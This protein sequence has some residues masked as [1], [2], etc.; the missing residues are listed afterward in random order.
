MARHIHS[1]LEDFQIIHDK[2]PP[3]KPR[4]NLWWCDI[5]IEPNRLY[6]WDGAKWIP[7]GSIAIGGGNGVDEEIII[8]L[9]DKINNLQSQ[10]TL[11]AKE[12]ATKVSKQDF[13]KD[14][15]GVLQRVT[16]A[17]SSIS[18]TADQIQSKVSKE[19]YERE[20]G[21]VLQRITTMESS[22]T[23]TAESIKS[24][25][26]KDN[27]ISMINQSAEKIQISADKISF[28]GTAI[29]DN[30][31]GEVKKKMYDIEQAANQ[32]KQLVDLWKVS[33]TTTINGGLI[34]A[35]TITAK[36]LLIGNF[37]NLFSNGTLEFG[38]KGFELSNNARILTENPYNGKFSLRLTLTGSFND[39]VD[40]RPIKVSPGDKFKYSV[41]ARTNAGTITDRI[42]LAKFIDANG[43]VE[44]FHVDSQR[45]TNS[46]NSYNGT[47]TV[48]SGI[49]A[50]QIG[51]GTTLGQT[52]GATYVYYD[53]LYCRSM[54]D[55][56]TI[57]DGTLSFDKA[58]GGN[59]VLGGSN[60]ESGS[61]YI[62]DEYGNNIV[63]GNK[64]GMTITGGKLTVQRP[65]G[66]KF[67]QD[68]IL[69]NDFAVTPH[70]PT[71]RGGNITT[72]SWYWATDKGQGFGRDEQVCEFFS[73][74]HSSRYVT[75]EMDYLMQ[76]DG[77][78]GTLGF[79]H[80]GVFENGQEKVLRY[81][82]FNHT[83]PLTGDAGKV[84]IDFGKPTY[85]KMGIYVVLYS[86]T[87]PWA[88]ARCVRVYLEG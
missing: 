49:V 43:N 9:E 72:R 54:L 37:D 64:N 80:A 47:F 15:K 53:N 58:K 50:M 87:G 77:G 30:L 70:Q 83:K 62:R 46:W 71:F 74:K 85:Q 79:I 63:T 61:F 38:P 36:S 19:V 73:F 33:G 23:Q 52:G 86:W 69:A 59:L 65:D 3:A 7:L 45:I 76:Y 60:N 27:I 48:P 68:G 28:E 14:M 41:Y 12:I 18:Q 13:E 66:A 84:T 32:A 56:N 88:L 39:V 26:K 20:Q 51:V 1:L 67:I 31:E 35:D 2:V 34:A 21:G 8:R 78:S 16:L 5:T 55:G 11:S 4:E 24:V 57:I 40:D 10:I 17:E 75:F 42:F 44:K 22:I 25:V 6:R 81:I 29:F 82:D